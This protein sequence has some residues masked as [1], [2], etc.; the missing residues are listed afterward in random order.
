MASKEKKTASELEELIIKEFQKRL[1]LKN[2]LSVIVSPNCQHPAVRPGNAA[3]F[4]MK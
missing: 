4:P 3:A 1:E 2:S